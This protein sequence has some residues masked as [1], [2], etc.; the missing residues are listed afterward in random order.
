MTFNIYVPSYNRSETTTTYKL[1][2]YCTYVVRKSEEEKYKKLNVPLLVV[3]D[4]KINSFTKVQQ[5]L[6]DNAEEDII[7]VIDDD[8][9]EFVYRLEN[10][11]RIKDK[12]IIIAEI[13]RIAQQIV[14]LDIGLGGLCVRD[15][16]YGYIGEV[17]FNGITG[18]VRYY[19]RNKLKSKYNHNLKFFQDVDFVL[20]EL[21]INRIIFRPNYFIGCAQVETNKGGGTSNKTIKMKEDCYRELR[22]KWGKDI[23]FNLKKNI[24]K[25]LVNR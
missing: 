4:E 12:E 24:T 7:C 1:L 17:N 2:D 13:E 14:D 9:Q 25:I 5:Y 8:I 6:I 15:I 23:N 18:S 11:E 10:K 22:K 16:P 19:N 21:L 3:E 20:Q